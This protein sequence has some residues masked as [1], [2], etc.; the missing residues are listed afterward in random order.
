M[1]GSL[2]LAHRADQLRDA[3][4]RIVQQDDGNVPTEPVQLMA[5]PGVGPYV[6]AAVA[7]GTG[8]LNAVLIDTNTVRVATRY[9]GIETQARDVR[10]QKPVT[11]AVAALFGGAA[12]RSEW[13]A[14]LDLAALICLPRQPRCSTCPLNIG[15]ETASRQF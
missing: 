9:F 10:R 15:C 3:A 14:V 7:V 12:G 2:G 11:N 1:L 6:A 13:W 4:R 8:Q 5:L